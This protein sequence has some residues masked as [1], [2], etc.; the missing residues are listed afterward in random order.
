MNEENPDSVAQELDAVHREAKEHYRNKN[1]TGYMH[2]FTSDLMYKQADGIVIGRDQLARDV[3]SQLARVDTAESSYSRESLQVAKD[4]VVEHLT[5]TATV[6][7]R[8]FLLFRRTW[9]VNRRGR[10]VW[11][12]TPA[13]WKIREVEVLYERVS[14]RA[15]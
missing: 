10:Y 6:T 3:A 7:V 4:S 14:S 8:V 13:G 9:H 5:Q 15:A 1:V 12:R 11:V 2:I